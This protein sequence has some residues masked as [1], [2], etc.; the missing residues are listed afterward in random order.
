MPVKQGLAMQKFD[1]KIFNEVAFGRYIEQF[2]RLRENRLLKSG[3]LVTDPTLNTLLSEQTGSHFATI[4]ILGRI[5][6]TV[7][8]YDGKTNITAETTNTYHQTVIALGR[9]AGFMEKDFSHDITGGVDFYAI[10]A[11]QLTDFWEDNLEDDL[12]AT[13][14]GL[15]DKSEADVKKTEFVTQHTLDIAE[16]KGVG[17]N[18]VNATTLNNAIQKAS[19]DKK[20]IFKVV[21][22]HSQVA[23]NL[24]NLQLLEH[25]KYTDKKGIERELTLAS[26]NSKEVII[27]DDGTM[28]GD[29]YVS[30]VLGKGAIK[31]SWLDVKVPQEMVRDAKTNGGET[32]LITRRRYCFAPHG[33]SYKTLSKISPM[34]DDLK[35]GTNWTLIDNGDE[36]SKDVFPHKLIPI[37]RVISKG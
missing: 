9:M 13:L 25:H 37:A 6:G 22:M 23:T 17:K 33:F 20:S 11:A 28:D 27:T 8:N 15:F 3:V 29:K 34:A 10:M 19:G 5:K 2:P 21:V 26:W 16:E 35:V 12:L 14:H 32:T 30:Y 24:E 4:P 1:H 31:F 7:Q 18:V 36:N